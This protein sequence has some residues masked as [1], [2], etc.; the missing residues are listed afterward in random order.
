[1]GNMKCD[2]DI[3]KGK[4]HSDICVQQKVQTTI[5]GGGFFE[6]ENKYLTHIYT[7]YRVSCRKHRVFSDYQK[8]LR[9]SSVF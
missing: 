6:I 4:L 7:K 1:M 5:W 9:A 2:L 8:S 3:L